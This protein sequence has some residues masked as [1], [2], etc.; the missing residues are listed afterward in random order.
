MH[1]LK[2]EI[3]TIFHKLADWLDFPCPVSAA[4]QNYSQDFFPFS[5]L[6]IFLPSLEVAPG[7]LIIQIQI[8]AVWFAQ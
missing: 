7:L 2:S 8:Q 1:G 4:L 5:L 3:L 6:F